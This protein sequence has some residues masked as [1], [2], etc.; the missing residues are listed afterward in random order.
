MTNRWTT[1]YLRL[2][3]YS[4]HAYLN[5]SATT[6]K[7]ST[8]RRQR[9]L[10][11]CDRVVPS[12]RSGCP[13]AVQRSEPHS[14][15]PTTSSGHSYTA[16]SLTIIGYRNGALNI[17]QNEQKNTERRRWKERPDDK[18]RNEKQH[19]TKSTTNDN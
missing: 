15:L 12:S 6:A 5:D 7:H 9:K 3:I 18:R 14:S 17:K 19:E 16:V 4:V 1:I 8:H 2:S 13:P 11:F 10:T